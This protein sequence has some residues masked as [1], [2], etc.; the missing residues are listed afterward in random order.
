[1]MLCESCGHSLEHLLDLRRDAELVSKLGSPQIPCPNCQTQMVFDDIPE[2][3]YAYLSTQPPLALSQAELG[4]LDADSGA[5]G[6]PRLKPITIA[7]HVEGVVTGMW[8]DG[9]LDR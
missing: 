6:L 8:L 1:P 5:V 4:I 9:T 7:K 2:S 3:Y